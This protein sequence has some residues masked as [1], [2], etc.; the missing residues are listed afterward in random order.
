MKNRLKYFISI[1]ILVFGTYT[2]AQVAI[3]KDGSNPVANSILHVKGIGGKNFTISDTLGLVGIGT[4]NPTAQL[5]IN[6][7]QATSLKLKSTSSTGIYS[8]IIY[9]SSENVYGFNNIVNT[10]GTGKIYGIKNEVYNSHNNVNY[11]IFTIV[12][13]QGGGSHYGNYN[14]MTNN[15]TGQQYGTVNHITNSGN[16]SHYGTKNLVFG[17]NGDKYG[18]LNV[19]SYNGGSKY[20]VRNNI[21]NDSLF[22]SFGVSNRIIAKGSGNT[23]GVKNLLTDNG[24]GTQY[25][26]FNEIENSGDGLHYGVYTDMSGN[27]EGDHY[28]SYIN[29]LG[30]GDG[31]QIGQYA[32]ITCSGSGNKYGV[33]DSISSSA[34]GQHYAI[35]GSALKSG[36]FAG[37]FNGDVKMTQRLKS[38]TSGEADMKAYVY[39]FVSSWGTV[40][41]DRS[42][43]GFTITHNSTGIYKVTIDGVSGDDYIVTATT[44]YDGTPILTNV[45][46]LSASGNEFNVLMFNLSGDL[47]N[48]SF[49]FVIYKK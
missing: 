18:V 31:Q 30:S 41:T 43:T 8:K 39:G 4:V 32:I 7:S 16:A 3:N 29:L 28:G 24:N 42:S 33:F 34:G 25:G 22:P 17:G 9:T 21:T 15:G 44:E 36:S 12:T 1:L 23:F 26:L 19:L 47:V 2:K 48:R 45:D 35:Y 5:E 37:F 11:G 40:S 13:S 20:G 49:H 38:P 27:G 46:Y 14:L 10:Y 6:S